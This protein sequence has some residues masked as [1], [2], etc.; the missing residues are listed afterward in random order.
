MGCQHSYTPAGRPEY[1][2]CSLCGT[3]RCL[4]PPPDD[5]YAADYWSHKKGHSTLH[6]QIFNIEVHR[7]RGVSK[8]DFVSRFVTV[9]DREAALDIGC[10]PGC[11]LSRLQRRFRFDRVVGVEI[12]PA[13][14]GVI[15]SIGAFNG[16]LLFG[17]FP[18]VTADLPDESMN[19]VV[20]LDVFEHSAEPEA[21]LAECF[22]LLKPEGELILM[23]PLLY[24]HD[25]TAAGM[26]APGEHM[27]LHGW[28]NISALLNDAGL[29]HVCSGQWAR[30]HELVVARR[31]LSDIIPQGATE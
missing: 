26:M 31:P 20:G 17:A 30:G 22:R 5:Y 23:M 2:K 12:D 14:E 3:Y 10:A 11:F 7:E 29:L 16:E 18:A 4:T 1:E 28:L 27:Y 15:R 6:E 19:L 8:N 13:V 21:F 24:P 9:L 25:D